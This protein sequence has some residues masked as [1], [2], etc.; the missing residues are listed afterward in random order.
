M[1]IKSCTMKIKKVE[2]VSLFSTLLFIS[3]AACKKRHFSDSIQKSES[4]GD[5]SLVA[6]CKISHNKHELPFE[7]FEILINKDGSAGHRK[8][9]ESQRIS[10]LGKPTPTGYII[11]YNSKVPKSPDT[12]TKE[13]VPTAVEIKKFMSG[14]ESEIYFGF[15]IPGFKKFQVSNS[16]N[17]NS[18]NKSETS[19]QI[20][21]SANADVENAPGVDKRSYAKCIWAE[22]YKSDLGFDADKYL[23]VATCNVVNNFGILDQYA[24]RLEILALKAPQKPNLAVLYVRKD[25]K[26]NVFHILYDRTK[27]YAGYRRTDE[28]APD[29]DANKFDT[30]F[31]VESFLKARKPTWSFHVELDF[32]TAVVGPNGESMGDRIDGIIRYQHST[33]APGNA[34]VGSKGDFES[35]EDSARFSQSTSM[36][37]TDLKKFKNGPESKTKGDKS[38]IHPDKVVT[39]SLPIQCHSEDA[40]I[41]SYLAIKK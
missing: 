38:L 18:S 35:F 30:Y 11:R 26:G 22:S 10:N 12:V 27:G 6:T 23:K 14:D 8:Q 13:I 31:P 4:T 28:P 17:Q 34:R 39:H 7:Q 32:G 41:E 9:L 3:A 16:M 29:Q 40:Q 19:V 2:I 15:F 20:V 1:T 37:P 33:V 5:W 36:V 25:D 24:D 21:S